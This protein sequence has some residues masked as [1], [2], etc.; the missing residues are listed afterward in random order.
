MLSPH[1]DD[2]KDV[3]QFQEAKAKLSEVFNQAEHSGIQLI[4]RNKKCFAVLSEEAYKDYMGGHR[5]VIDI[6]L[7]CP[8]PEIELDIERNKDPLRDFDF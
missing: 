1:S 3:W 7:N 4:R 8:H 5:S 2:H 6:F